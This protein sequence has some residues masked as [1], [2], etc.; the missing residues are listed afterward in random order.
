MATHHL[1]TLARQVASFVVPEV[2]MYEADPLLRR[3]AMRLPDGWHGSPVTLEIGG[4]FPRVR[5]QADDH[6]IDNA[7][8]ITPIQIFTEKWISDVEVA[9]DELERPDK[10]EIVR[11]R[12]A[13]MAES[14]RAHRTG[15]LYDVLDRNPKAIGG[16]KFFDAGH[17]VIGAPVTKKFA[18]FSEGGFAN[19]EKPTLQELKAEIYQARSR[20]LT[21][22]AVRQASVNASFL[23]KRLMILC[24]HIEYF[25]QLSL[26]QAEEEIEGS[27]NSLRGKFDVEMNLHRAP[28]GDAS[29]FRIWVLYADDQ[30]VTVRA[31]TNGQQ[32]VARVLRLKPLTWVETQTGMRFE[33]D[34][35]AVYHEDVFRVGVKNTYIAAP[36]FPQAAYE[37]RPGAST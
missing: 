17:R 27:K 37:I 36:G 31:R 24:N 3:L 22:G 8:E 6:R 33:Q 2:P 4:E 16:K 14:I 28:K 26:L 13:N 29:D 9:T 35:N 5:K 23:D 25:T 20:L 1:P 15:L 7:G 11:D 10:I 30:A 21:Q 19:P 12:S 34:L 18:N 32:R